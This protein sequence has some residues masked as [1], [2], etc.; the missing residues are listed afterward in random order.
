MT[1]WN[2]DFIQ[3]YGMHGPRYTSYPSSASYHEEITTDD[4]WRVLA[5]G[6]D[7]HRP[8]SLYMHIPFCEHVC[9]FCACNRIVTA[10]RGRASD[11][12]QFLL[13]ELSLK[14]RKI[15]RQRPVTQLHWG[16]G[17]PTF[18]SDAEITGL[19]YHT[20]RNY[21][22]LDNDRGDYSV[23]IDPR[24]VT[25]KRIALLRGL[26]FNRASI[27]VQDLD[28]HVQKAVNRVQPV[29]QVRDVFGW[30]K[31][32]GFRSINID[33][34]Y[35]L[36]WQSESSM[37]RT[38]TQVLALRPDRIAL[39]NYQ[40]MPERFKAQRHINELA[41]PATDEKLRMLVRAGEMIEQAGYRWIGMDQ[42]ALPG[43]SLA[44]AQDAGT[45]QR[46]IQGYT[47]HGDADVIGFGTT[48]ISEIGPLYAQNHKSL[49]QW[50]SAVADGEVP[51]ER[52]VELDFDDRVRRDLIRSL[53]CLHRIDLQ[54][55]GERWQ[56]DAPAYFS[57]ELAAL[58]P[59]ADNGVL[60]KNGTGIILT[61]KGKLVSRSLAMQFDR[62]HG[63]SERRQR[64]ARIL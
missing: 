47:L 38:L 50:Q 39:F 35:G 48:A 26:G 13:D 8:V 36:P 29:E 30:L 62:Y 64:L 6:N 20:A 28:P 14:A 52:G 31:D 24:T 51:L 23:E 19:V 41:L 22:L 21:H 16:G 46:N 3:R 63:G 42:F 43:D 5:Q 4:F 9:F 7:E 59:L 11:Y 56:I 32:H 45:L 53:L 27:G 40:H 25:E 12:L 60:H 1:S 44:Q 18:L 2:P 61:N 10:D 55:L 58:A 37:V 15:D 34:M 33:L 17:T 54:Q 49:S 57:S